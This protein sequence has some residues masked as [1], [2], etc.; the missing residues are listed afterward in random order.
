M[1]FYD[2]IPDIHGQSAKLVA[3]LDRLG[4]RRA[5]GRWRGDRADRQIVFLGDFIDRGPDSRGVLETVRDLIADGCAVAVMGNHELN[6]IHFHND[7]P[8]TSLPLRPRS[9][10]NVHQHQAF[11]GQ[12]PPGSEG[13]REWIGWMAGLPL[14]LDLGPF[15]AVHA[16]WDGQAIRR[17]ARIAPGGVLPRET[18]LAAGRADHPLNRHVETLTKGPEHELGEG[19]FISD[20][21]GVR[22]PAA[23]LAWWKQGTDRW[24]DA[25][26][27]AHQP[28]TLPEGPVP[29]AL[30]HALYPPDE[31]PVFFGHY[32]LTGD[33]E[34]HAPNAACLDYSAGVDDNPLVAYAWE[35]GAPGLSVEA[36][37]VGE[38]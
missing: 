3:M 16:C 33:P 15:R 8:R 12:F 26:V 19:C 30:A 13:A 1:A 32:W 17:L 4:Y 31:K 2:I 6:A 9:D 28:M 25:L 34:I 20:K 21:E 35:P 23:R 10:K 24:E 36:I 11:L 29:D 18:L 27:S 7:D 5:D 37:V 14:W 22:R 38:A